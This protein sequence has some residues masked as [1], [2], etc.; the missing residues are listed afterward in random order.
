ML[1][2]S[3][4]ARVIVELKSMPSK[5]ESISRCAWVDDESVRFARSQA[6]RRRR[7]ARWFVFKSFLNFFLNSARK[8][9]TMRLSKSSPPKCVSP[10]VALTSKMPSSMVRS[11]TS[12]V[13]P[14]R[15]K[16][17]TFFSSPFL[18][19]PYAIAAAVGSL[20]MRRTLMPAIEPASLVAW[21]CESLKYAGTV[22]MALDT[23]RPRKPS[24]VSFIFT[25]T[26][27]PTCDGDMASPLT[28]T[29]ASS[30]DGALT[31]S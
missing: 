22:T 19:R 5:S 1:R 27:E 2:S 8:W 10:A 12:K 15:S 21:R 28:L 29:H 26:M 14:P 16:I 30:L 7:S 13:P 23:V 11:E 31:I 6:V 20:M 25:R 18:S 4:R 24:A 17:S 3:K 9:S